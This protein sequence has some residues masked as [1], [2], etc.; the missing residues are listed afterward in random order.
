MV[1]GEVWTWCF[2]FQSEC[3]RRPP[4]AGFGSG[5]LSPVCPVRPSDRV[6][7]TSTVNLNPLGEWKD[8][9]DGSDSTGPIATTLGPS[10]PS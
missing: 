8:V 7:P 9:G 3:R 6:L 1:C 5:L 10:E 4:G 2:Q